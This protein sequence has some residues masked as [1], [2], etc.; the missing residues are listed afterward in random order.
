MMIIYAPN[1][2]LY[3]KKYNI[4]YTIGILNGV[5]R[6]ISS[7]GLRA[8]SKRLFSSSSFYIFFFCV[9]PL[10]RHRVRRGNRGNRGYELRTERV[11]LCI[12][13]L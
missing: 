8:A 7:I 12:I 10:H 3:H 11:Y 5:T 1:H 2:I 4:I 13:I 9:F 6:Y